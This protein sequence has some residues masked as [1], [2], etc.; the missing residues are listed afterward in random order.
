MDKR[1]TLTRDETLALV[2]RYKE[3][4][5]PLFASLTGKAENNSKK[6]FTFAA[7]TL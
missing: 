2:H 6:L 1:K 5:H 3:V 7:Y 4:I